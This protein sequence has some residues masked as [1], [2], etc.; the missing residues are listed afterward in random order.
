MRDKLTIFSKDLE[1]RDR[2]AMWT[3]DDN[4][5]IYKINDD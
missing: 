4:Y 3:C 1:M 2:V 5:A